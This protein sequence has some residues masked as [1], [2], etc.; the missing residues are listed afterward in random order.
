M[1]TEKNQQ[2]RIWEIEYGSNMEKRSVNAPTL[3]DAL[4]KAGIYQTEQIGKYPKRD[5]KQGEKD[6]EIQRI[7]LVWETDVD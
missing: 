7:E 5:R 6:Y 4:L 2:A 3:D 1:Q